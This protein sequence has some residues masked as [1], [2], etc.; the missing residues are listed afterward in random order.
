M[1]TR[2]PIL[3]LFAVLLSLF[4]TPAGANAAGAKARFEYKLRLADAKGKPLKGPQTVY[5]SV[6][7]GG[8]RSLNSGTKVYGEKATIMPGRDGIV[9]YWL[10]GGTVLFGSLDLSSL[11]TDEPVYA[12]EAVGGESSPKATRSLVYAMDNVWLAISPGWSGYWHKKNAV[13]SGLLTSTKMAASARRGLVT[14]YPDLKIQ[15]EDGSIIDCS[16]SKS[17][18]LQEFFDYCTEHRVDGYI[19]GGASPS[20]GPIG[21]CSSVPV[22]VHPAQGFRLDTGAITLYFSAAIGFQT[23]LT[24]DSCMMVDFRIRGQLVNRGTGYDLAF[25][26][27]NT[28][29]L[30]TFV[31]P[32]IVD[33]LFYITT[34]ATSGQGVLMEGSI[35]FNTFVFNEINGGDIGVHVRSGSYSNNKFT[36]KHIH[37]QNKTAILVETGATNTWEVNINPDARDPVGIDTAGTGDIWFINVHAKQKPGLI[38]EPAARANQFHIMGLSGGFENRATNPT[39]RFFAAPGISPESVK[40]GFSV[41]TPGVPEPGAVVVNRNPFNVTVMIL[42]PGAVLSW[43][44]A[45]ASGLSQSIDGPFT[46]GQSI[47]LAPGESI[48][49]QYAPGGAPSWRW[50]GM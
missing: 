24:I 28:L 18:G 49:I 39:N 4:C 36:C 2:K 13:Y 45:D 50:R 11:K 46:A 41:E 6:W 48:S 22:H 34:I 30:D 10:G 37:N 35:N 47:T 42:K 32:T 33:S 29:P 12:Q 1:R 15:R 43:R 3:I 8:S 19:V 25:R 26:P 9:A 23:A 38:L 16:R 5:L 14:L 7:R 31:G 21:Y 44:I 40:L 20:G 27:T 17:S